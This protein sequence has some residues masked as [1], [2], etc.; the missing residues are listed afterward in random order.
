MFP[1]LAISLKKKFI[2]FN[3]I[4][5]YFKQTKIIDRSLVSLFGKINIQFII[6]E[7][8]KNGIILLMHVS[9]FFVYLLNTALKR[10]WKHMKKHL[11]IKVYLYFYF[12]PK[13]MYF[14]SFSVLSLFDSW[15]LN[16]TGHFF[17][18]R[19]QDLKYLAFQE[20]FLSW[21]WYCCNWWLA[22]VCFRFVK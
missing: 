17:I 13:M 14:C 21:I 11:N 9:Y 20:C 19:L 22:K 7:T 4:V 8:G 15:Y 2:Y 16:F 5:F 6:F 12:M 10:I 1:L 18:V 3:L